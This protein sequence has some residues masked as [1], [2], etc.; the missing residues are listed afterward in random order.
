M[1][2]AEFANQLIILCKFNSGQA[3]FISDF[4]RLK[5]QSFK[6]PK[7][8]QLK[9]FIAFRL[10]SNLNDLIIKIKALPRKKFLNKGNSE[11]AILGEMNLV[12]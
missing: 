9:G 10:A 5:I 12:T 1:L 4:K 8:G 3:T 2:N 6:K 11:Q 7:A